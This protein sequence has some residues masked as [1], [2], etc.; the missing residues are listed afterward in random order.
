MSGHIDTERMHDLIDGLVPSAEAAADRAHLEACPPCGTEYRHL[1]DVVAAL[2]GLPVEA[3]APVDL[4]GGIE[5]RIACEPVSDGLSAGEPSASLVLPFRARGARRRFVFTMPQLAAAAVV[6]SLLSA[7]AMWTAMSRG[8]PDAPIASQPAAET[9]GPAARMAAAGEAAYDT[10]LAEL[11]EL[12][13]L[14]RELMA[15]ETLEALESSLS[16]IDQA[17]AEIREALRQDP[18]SELLTRLL[19]T[20]Q[21]SKLRVLRQA[22][23]AVHAQS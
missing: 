7:G 4:W 2:R 6:V 15:P 21:R 13:A 23:T 17:L 10:A 14:N 19:A 11:E 5:E 12:V 18:N 1:E 3:A 20:Q 8:A 9:Q 16:T 22:A